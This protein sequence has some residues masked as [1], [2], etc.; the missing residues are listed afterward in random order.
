MTGQIDSIFFDYG[1]TLFDYYPSNA[2]IWAKIAN[3]LGVSIEPDDPR[4]REGMRTQSREFDK[5]DKGFSEL[6]EDELFSLNCFVLAA[7]GVDL[8]G[9][10]EIVNAEF[11]AREQ[12]KMF[13]IFP[14]AAE[15]L[16]QIKQKGIKVGL[17]SN[18]GRR[19][20]PSRRPSLEE[21]G[22][23]HHFDAIIL[24]VE[25]GV[26]KPDKK[27]F[28]IALREI[29]TQDPRLAMHVGDSLKADVRGARNAGLIPIFF[30]P[31]DLH[32]SEDAIKIKALS[33]V[34]QYL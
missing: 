6:T 21:H 16:R 29:G 14:D 26:W 34:L 15:T 33:G 23:L 12:G 27:I 3:R 20:A 8:E 5:I 11:I 10:R 24:S 19:M 7:M 9:S 1:G 17:L 28:E 2:E 25:V 13:Q 18:V 30:D 22:I 31:L 4:I 32:S